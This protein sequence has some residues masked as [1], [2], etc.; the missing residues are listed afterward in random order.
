MRRKALIRM[1]RRNGWTKAREGGN[2]TIYAKGTEME[3]VARHAE[4]DEGLARAIIRRR[5]LK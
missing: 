5:G 3:A 1:L 2:H 4:I